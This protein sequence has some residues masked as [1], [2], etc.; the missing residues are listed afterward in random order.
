MLTQC[1]SIFINLPLA[2]LDRLTLQRH[3]DEIGSAMSDSV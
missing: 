1:I 2:A 3:L